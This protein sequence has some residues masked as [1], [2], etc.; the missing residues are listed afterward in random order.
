MD[1]HV[2]PYVNHSK[3]LIYYVVK[4]KATQVSISQGVHKKK[5]VENW[6]LEAKYT[7]D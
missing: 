3:W 1:T 7:I 6:K 5:T 4:R 2:D